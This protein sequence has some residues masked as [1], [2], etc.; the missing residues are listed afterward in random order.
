MGP[1]LEVTEGVH[2]QHAIALDRPPAAAE[3]YNVEW[4]CVAQLCHE[5]AYLLAIRTNSDREAHDARSGIDGAAYDVPER[6]VCMG[7]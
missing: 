1:G 6:G 5:P 4:E 3:Q 7:S 2:D